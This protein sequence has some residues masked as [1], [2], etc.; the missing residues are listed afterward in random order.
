MVGTPGRAQPANRWTPDRSLARKSVS[1][2]NADIAFTMM[3]EYFADL[4]DHT[5]YGRRWYDGL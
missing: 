5:K 4:V 2:F 1:A 3:K